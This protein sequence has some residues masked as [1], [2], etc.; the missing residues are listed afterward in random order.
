MYA[1]QCVLVYE[2]LS[3]QRLHAS[4]PT[5]EISRKLE[6]PDASPWASM[7]FRLAQ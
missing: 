3:S 1:Y 4:H 2:L 6:M 5:P 7:G